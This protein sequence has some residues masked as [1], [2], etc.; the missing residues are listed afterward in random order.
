[1][2]GQGGAVIAKAVEGGRG[3]FWRAI[4]GLREGGEGRGFGRGRTAREVDV[5]AP[6]EERDTQYPVPVPCDVPKLHPETERS[7]ATSGI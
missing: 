4:W 6:E 5:G 7:S 1:M 3:R 2:A